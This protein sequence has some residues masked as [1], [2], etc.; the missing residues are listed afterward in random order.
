L[1]WSRTSAKVSGRLG[2]KLKYPAGTAANNRKAAVRM[3]LLV[4][5]RGFGKRRRNEYRE[6]LPQH[7][8]ARSE[9]PLLV[10]AE[11]ILQDIDQAF[12]AVGKMA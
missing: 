12:I 5:R 4:G 9:P 6:D 8:I 1:K 2:L 11:R 7:L 3:G 10:T